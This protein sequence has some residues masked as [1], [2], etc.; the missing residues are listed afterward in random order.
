MIKC[1]MNVFTSE[2]YDIIYNI[3]NTNNID[4][5]NNSELNELNELNKLSESNSLDNFP[6]IQILFS[7]NG[8]EL[9]EIVKSNKPYGNLEYVFP[10][11][12]I[13]IT[14]KCNST[15][16]F[17]VSL[18]GQ[19]ILCIM[20]INAIGTKI[21]NNCLPN[22]T[23]IIKKNDDN[24]TKNKTTVL[25]IIDS[26]GWAF[27]NISKNIKKY[28]NDYL[29]NFSIQTITYPKLHSL[30]K[31]NKIEETITRAEHILFFWY[32]GPN[33]EILDYFYNNKKVHC[34]K[35]INLCVYDYSKWI[36]TIDSNDKIYREGITY[37]FNKID[38]YLYG[39]N[40]I[41]YYISNTFSDPIDKRKIGSYP[42][43]DGVDT[44]LFPNFGYT[45]NILTREK[46][47]VG[48]IGNSNPRVHGIN[49][50]FSIIKKCIDGMSDK[51]MF[52]PLDIHTSG[53]M[54]KHENVHCYMSLVDIIV[55]Y[56][57]FEG[58]PNQIL[59]ASSCGKCWISTNVGIVSELQHTLNKPCGIIINR[60]EGELKS[61]L[62]RLYENRETLIEYGKN[63][64]EAIEKKWA[65]DKGVKQFY[66]FFVQ[67]N[68]Q[69]S[70]QI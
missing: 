47:V 68:E 3:T 60:N 28:I 33:L 37:F 31:T 22:A 40:F 66:D 54:I 1:T 6:G 45:P 21:R 34:I 43:F 9:I 53:V 63:G 32:A 39:C 44:N 64:R 70:Q 42:V 17:C 69:K 51:F 10:L 19:T 27:D 4:R 67:Q 57:M 48:W 50:G 46:L 52:I 61:A 30:I 5:A 8:N 35:T 23:E 38:N 18:K 29:P 12:N 59:E 15:C 20:N 13:E 7:L 11:G 55:C 26:Y 25:L 24:D 14:V 2:P 36:N 16:Y 56:S 65:W 41:K 49:K 62:L 58:T